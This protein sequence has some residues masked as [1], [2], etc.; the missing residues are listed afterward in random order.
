[1]SFVCKKKKESQ[2]KVTQEIPFESF[3][4]IAP[5]AAHEMK[6]WPIEYWKDFLSKYTDEKIVILGGPADHFCEELEKIDSSRIKNLAGKLSLIESCYTIVKS[7]LLLS[8]DT[9]L[10][11]VADSLGIKGIVLI[12]PSAFGYPG[13]EQIKT[14][15][16]DLACKPC[17]KDGSGGCVQEVYQKCMKDITVDQVITSVRH[18]IN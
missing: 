1:M 6:K 14:L 18:S 3:I 8:A 11:H 4:T 5:S 10:L 15:E 12:G 7:K 9:G 13:N 16:T 2:Q 17:S